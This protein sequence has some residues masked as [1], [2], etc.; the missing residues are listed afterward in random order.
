LPAQ[1]IPFKKP[2]KLSPPNLNP[3]TI[4][5]QLIPSN[6]VVI[7]PVVTVPSK[8]NSVSH[9]TTT[10]LVP[11]QEIPVRLSLIPDSTRFQEIPSPEKRM[12]P[13]HPTAINLLPLHMTSF[14][15]FT[16]PDADVV[17]NIPSVE[18]TIVD[19]EL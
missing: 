3:D 2:A 11:D 19:E 13:F 9:P 1:A 5:V 17:H 12:V 8:T 4:R 16:V 15:E 18:V 10:Y 7:V 14:K 6:E